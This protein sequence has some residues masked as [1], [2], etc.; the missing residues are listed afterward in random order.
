[1]T[2]CHGDAD[3]PRD[4]EFEDDIGWND[5]KNQREHV[6]LHCKE[7]FKAHHSRGELGYCDRCADRIEAGEDLYP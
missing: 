7:T 6:C 3:D 2:Y 1:M 4:W 5:P